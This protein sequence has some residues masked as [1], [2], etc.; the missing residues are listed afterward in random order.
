M[1]FDDFKGHIYLIDDDPSIRRSLAY[2]LSSVRYS[3]QTFDSPSAFLRDALPITPAVILLDIRMPDMNGLAL[4]NEMIARGRQT[5]IIFISGESQPSEIIEAMKKGAIDFLIKPFRLEALMNAID[6]AL[7]QD[8][9]LQ[10]QKIISLNVRERF[11]RLTDKER[12]VCRWMIKG[13]GNKEIANM[14]GSAPAT[15]KLHRSRVLEKM[16]CN[17]LPE[18]IAL[19]Q[20]SEQKIMDFF[21]HPGT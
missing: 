2:S 19:A 6:L 17:N 15:V 12:E 5:P 3:I 20:D 10:N 1:N 8:K 9:Q 18:L 14:N 11:M 4:Q 7:Q 21:N 13:Y 16:G